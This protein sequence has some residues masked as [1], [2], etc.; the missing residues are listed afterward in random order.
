[1][2]T[3]GERKSHYEMGKEVLLLTLH[4][5]CLHFSLCV[6]VWKSESESQP[7][8]HVQLF[9]TP[10]AVARQAPLSMGILQARILPFPSIP[11]HSPGDRL[12]LGMKPRPPILQADSLPSEPPRVCGKYLHLI[13]RFNAHL[14]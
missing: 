11:F 9:A 14:G 8:N 2:V 7:F 12:N 10:W 13:S 5:S 4:T 3:S 6:Y 1:M